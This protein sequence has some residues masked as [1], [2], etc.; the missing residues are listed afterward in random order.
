MSAEEIKEKAKK[1]AEPKEV[2]VDTATVEMLAKAQ[3]EGVETIFDRAVTMKPCNI[4]EQGTCCKNCSQGPCRLPLTKKG[5]EGE[6][7]RKGLCGA[8]PET[9]AAR[10]F[11][12]MVAAG[13]AAHSDHGRGVALV[14]DLGHGLDHGHVAEHAGLQRVGADVLQN[15]AG[16]GLNDVDGDGMD[17]GDAQGVLDRDGGDGGGR[18]GAERGDR[19]DVGLDSRPATGV[20]TGQDENATEGGGR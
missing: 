6:D 14:Q 1:A 7:T 8:T 13:T 20:G 5:M 12:R 18:I 9:I 17:A 4:G 10:N 11:A 15:G 19:L 2:S 16:L 3:K